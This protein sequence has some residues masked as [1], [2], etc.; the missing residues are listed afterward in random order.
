M[1]TTINMQPKSG[2]LCSTLLP[3]AYQVMDTGTGTTNIIAKCNVMDQVTAI[4]TQVGGS[5]RLAPHLTVA[6]LYRFDGSEIF[7]TVTKST[8]AFIKNTLGSKSGFQNAIYNWQDESTF[9]VNVNFYREYIDPATGL[10][11]VDPT[12]VA[13]SWIYILEGCPDKPFLL[14]AVA[15][16]GTNAGAFNWFTAAYNSEEQSKRYFTNYPIKAIG[17]QRFSN[18]TIHESEQYMLTYQSPRTNFTSGCPYYFETKTYDAGNNLLNTHQT[19]PLTET[20]NVQSIMVGFWDMVNNLTP[21]GLEGNYAG[22]EFGF[23]DHYTVNLM[24]NTSSTSACSMH[25][26]LTEYRF[27]VDRSCIKNGGYMRFVFKNMLGGYD[28]VT[29]NGKFTKKVKNKFEDFEKT[30]GYHDWKETMAFGKSNWSNQNIERYTVSTQLM[31]KDLATH[32][33]EM[34]SSTQVYLKHT[35]VA[36]L[37]VMGADL[38]MDAYEHPYVFYPIVIKSGNVNVSKTQDNY[39]SLKFQFEM[40]VNQRNP[41]Y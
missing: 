27:K 37:R 11:I 1:A 20:N 5:Y 26:A 34:L 17:H 18:V 15:D 25:K 36:Q 7:N 32:F 13:S 14:Q 29:S 12:A 10:I 39:A 16:N 21:N 28:M 6:G 8:L 41:R 19:P 30:L 38:G 35:E 31:R 33:A 40:A 24:H 2:R 9:Y 3:I 22:Y 23:V 4:Q